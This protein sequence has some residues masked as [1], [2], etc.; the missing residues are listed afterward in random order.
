[1]TFTFKTTATAL[2]LT[3]VLGSGSAFAKAHD[4]GVA[5]GFATPDNT[6]AFIQSLGGNGVSG[7]QNGGQRGDT[8]SANGSDNRTVP[9]VGNGANAE[10]N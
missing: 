3:M 9:V 8:A 5:D 6:G 1:M 4:Q 10:P 2:A 7:G